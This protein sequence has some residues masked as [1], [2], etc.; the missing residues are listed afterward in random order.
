MSFV[1]RKP[2]ILTTVQDLGRSGSKRFGIN[3]NG[4]M[5]TAAVRAVNIALGN[6]ENDA[7]LEM[8]FPAPEIDF[9]DATAFG[10]SGGD[11]AAELDSKAVANWSTANA[12]KGSVL[13]FRRKN[14]GNRAYLAV[15]GGIQVEPWLGSRST[16]ITGHAGGFHGRALGVGD[17]IQCA[18]SS[19][20]IPIAIGRSFGNRYAASTTLRILPSGEFE[21]LTALSELALTNGP[22]LIT[23]ESNRMG[24]RLRGEPLHLLHEKQLVS[25]AATFGTMQ[26]LPD[27]QIII[28]MADHQTAGGYPRIGNI[29]SADLPIAGQLGPGDQ[30]V[31]KTV[32]LREAENARARFERDIDFFKVGCRLRNGAAV[33]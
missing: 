2:G 8:H 7:V 4:A 25:S 22:F 26:L 16:N 18:E 21:M 3:P 31:F 5:D 27:G 6:D 10:I 1:I 12:E 13:K 17:L 30:V 28:L 11:F 9:E 32:T 33:L 23:R 24:F 15:K 20:E 19:I 29:I 14:S